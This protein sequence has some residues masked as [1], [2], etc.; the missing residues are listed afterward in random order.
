M[1]YL[2][3]STFTFKIYK[4]EMQC[5]FVSLISHKKTYHVNDYKKAA[6]LNFGSD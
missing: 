1:T 6:L 2:F 3:S 5:K 4:S